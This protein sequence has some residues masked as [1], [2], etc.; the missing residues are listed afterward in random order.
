M[1]VKFFRDSLSFRIWLKTEG[2]NRIELW[3]GI[4]KKES[5]KASITYPEALDEA[6][7]FGW[8]DGLRKSISADAYTIRF[9]PRK[10]KSQWSKVNIKRVQEL[11]HRGQMQLAGLK[12]FEGATEQPRKY[13]YEQRNKAQFPAPDE[14]RFRANRKAWE[15]FQSQ[16]PW[17][18]R[19]ATYWVISAK[20]EETRKRRLAALIADSERCKPIKALA[21]PASKKTTKPR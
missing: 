3:V 14:T 16:P 8:I 12:A 11:A 1:K 7:C 2:K 9:T 17:Y 15:F 5:G 13:S 20:K 6:L 18:R 21:R 19:T 4:C 10:P